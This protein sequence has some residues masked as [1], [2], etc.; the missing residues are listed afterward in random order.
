MENKSTVIVIPINKNYKKKSDLIN[1]IQYAWR[2]DKAINQLR[3]SYGSRISSPELAAQDFMETGKIF[4]KHP[5]TLARHKVISFEDGLLSVPQQAFE[6]AEEIAAYYTDNFQVA[7]GVHE[8]RND[9]SKFNKNYHIH[10]IVNSVNYKNGKIFH[11]G[12]SDNMKFQ[13][14]I[15]NIMESY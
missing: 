10:L 3:G 11:E 8:D 2:K 7:Y 15:R 9:N 6:I 1:L 4:D 12:S 13:E 14:Y 5:S